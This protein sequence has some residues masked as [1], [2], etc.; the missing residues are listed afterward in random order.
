M[1]LDELND[2]PL[3]LWDEGKDGVI[4][5]GCLDRYS[6]YRRDRHGDIWCDRCWRERK[7]QLIKLN[8]ASILKKR[9]T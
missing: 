2:N 3:L 4:C 9:L 6:R 7:E 8:V 5:V 1:I